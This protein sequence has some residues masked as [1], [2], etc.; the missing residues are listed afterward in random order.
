MFLPGS[1]IPKA[2][3]TYDPPNNK[4]I[5]NNHIRFDTEANIS[6]SFEGG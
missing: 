2:L 4:A 3:K 5:P 1:G 6:A